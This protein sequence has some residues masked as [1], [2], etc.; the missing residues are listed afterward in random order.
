MKMTKKHLDQWPARAC[1]V[2]LLGLLVCVQTTPLAFAQTS[3]AELQ[4]LSFIKKLRLARA[5]D[6]NAQYSVANDYE[7]GLN[8]ARQDIVQAVRWYREAALQGN[9]DAFFKLSQILTKGE[10]SVPQDVPAAMK[11]LE[12]AASRGHGP[13]QNAY[14]IRLQQGDGVQKDATKAAAQFEL[15]AAQN[16][17]AAQVNLGLLLVKGEGVTK[18][19]PKAFKLFESAAATGDVWALNNLGGMHEMGWGTAKDLNKARE[20]YTAAQS[21]GST[22]ATTNLA[23]LDSKTQ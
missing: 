20:F 10:G 21:K 5:G 19:L 12:D 3:Q 18:D 1:A 14:G 17:P 7:G 22:L 6:S 13:S 11:L 4:G 15:A 23:R 9:L 8:Q 16:L 2:A